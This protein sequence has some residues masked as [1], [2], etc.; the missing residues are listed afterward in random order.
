MTTSQAGAGAKYVGSAGYF[1]A[2]NMGLIFR[3]FSRIDDRGGSLIEV[4]LS[5]K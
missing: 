3:I 1:P 4:N 2:K 5:T